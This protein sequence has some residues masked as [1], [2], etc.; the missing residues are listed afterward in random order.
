[1]VRTK[2]VAAL[3]SIGLGWATASPTP[4]PEADPD[5]HVDRRGSGQEMPKRD[6]GFWYANMDHTSRNIRGFA[7]NLDGDLD[8]E[9]YRAV[10]PGDGAGIQAAINSATNGATRHGQWFASQP[11]VSE[12]KL[13]VVRI[14]TSIGRLHPARRVHHH[15]DYPH[16]H[17]HNHHG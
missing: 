9:V 15:G 17:R 5:A 10:K 2:L 14:L 7:P 3:L 13:M 12:F 6:T 11:R 4:R 16:E 1:M 8:Y